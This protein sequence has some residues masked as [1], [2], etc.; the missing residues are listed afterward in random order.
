[1]L[2][3][4]IKKPA[5]LLPKKHIILISHMRANTTLLG[6][7]FGS[8]HNI[9][10]YYEHHIGYYS[11]KSLIRKKIKFSRENPAEPVT[12]YYFDKILHNE[13]HIKESIFQQDN[14]SLF[15]MLRRPDMAIKSIVKLYQRVNPSHDFARV[16][17]AT[18]YYIERLSEIENIAV[19]YAKMKDVYYLDS[20]TIINNTDYTLN[21]I[22]HW[23]NLKPTLNSE[24]KLFELSGKRKHG[25][26][27]E[28]IK[29]G[30]VSKKP[31]NYENIIIEDELSLKAENAYLKTKKRILCLAKSQITL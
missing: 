22:S 27:S 21:K 26:S 1:M 24:Y 12:D 31:S 2:V 3:E 5:L 11:W 13:H 4:A 6:H 8:H 18:K 23:F 15:F 16:D 25:D 10:G 20:E 17:L 29:N 28:N 30:F 19:K 7:I 9:S 14:V